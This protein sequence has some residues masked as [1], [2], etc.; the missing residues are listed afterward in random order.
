[1]RAYIN[2]TVFKLGLTQIQ[3]YNENVYFRRVFGECKMIEMIRTSGH[4]GTT[5][6]ERLG[7]VYV[8]GWTMKNCI[9]EM[10]LMTEMG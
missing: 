7:N 2:I 4:G 5:D 9:K 3:Q 1:M 6:L 8:N 10:Y